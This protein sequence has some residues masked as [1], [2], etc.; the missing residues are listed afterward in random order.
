MSGGDGARQNRNGRKPKGRGTGLPTMATR[1]PGSFPTDAGESHHMQ[2][3]T[4]VTHYLD[5]GTPVPM[6]RL[7]GHWLKHAGF[8][9]GQ[10]I[11]VEVAAGT[12]VLRGV[13]ESA[14]PL[15]HAW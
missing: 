3:K 13:T 8:C 1:Q 9:Q 11:Q 4:T 15:A 10:K 14:E 2:R 5:Q 6:I 12:L 7:R